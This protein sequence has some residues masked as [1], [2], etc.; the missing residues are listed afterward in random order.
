MR[1]VSQPRLGLGEFLGDVQDVVAD[2]LEVGEQLGVDDAGLLVAHAAAHP[3]QLVPGGTGRS[4]RRSAAPSGPRRPAT[5]VPRLVVKQGGDGLQGH[6][7]HVAHGAEGRRG[8]ADVFIHQA[9]V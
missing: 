6:V 9:P 3:V 7:P 4:C 8:E 1:T 5:P 2:T